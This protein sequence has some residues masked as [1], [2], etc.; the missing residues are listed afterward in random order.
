MQSEYVTIFARFSTLRRETCCVCVSHGNGRG[1]GPNA[2]S[3]Q[4]WVYFWAHSQRVGNPTNLNHSHMTYTCTVLVTLSF[5]IWQELLH[6]DQN[7]NLTCPRLRCT[8]SIISFRLKNMNEFNSFKGIS[9]N[10]ENI[11]KHLHHLL[12]LY[13]FRKWIMLYVYASVVRLMMFFFLCVYIDQ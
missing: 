2:A 11:G 6:T 4:N 7:E 9:I 1:T 5:H 8:K 10:V 12:L 13:L 3:P